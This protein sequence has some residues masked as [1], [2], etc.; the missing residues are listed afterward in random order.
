MRKVYFIAMLLLLAFVFGCTQTSEPSVQRNTLSFLEGYSYLKAEEAKYN[1][2]DI[3]DVH[4]F[5]L[6]LEKFGSNLDNSTDADALRM[7]L[8][9]R[10]ALLD[11]QKN[12]VFAEKVAEEVNC[13]NSTLEK[14]ILD[15]LSFFKSRE[16]CLF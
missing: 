6:D 1:L 8:K 4:S 2:S 14:Y 11:A 3:N 10:L 13:S 15:A 12:V 16:F 5:E 7:F 9:F